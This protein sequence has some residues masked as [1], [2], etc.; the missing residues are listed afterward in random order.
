M[1]GTAPGMQNFVTIGLRI[2]VLQI[3]DFAVPFD[4]TTLCFKERA[5]F[6]FRYYFVN[7]NQ[8]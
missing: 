2:S 7:R 6:C 3:R 4:V 8:I 1:S 5:P